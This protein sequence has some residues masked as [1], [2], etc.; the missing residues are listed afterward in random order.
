MDRRA[1]E[2]A[3][4]DGLVDGGEQ[5]FA[6]VANVAGV[7]SA[8]PGHHLR[9]SGQLGGAGVSAGDVDQAR[10]QA[11]GAGVHAR[12]DQGFHPLQSRRNDGGLG[13]SHHGPAHAALGDQ[14]ND[15]R[16][17]PLLADRGKIA[18]HVHRAT[19]AVAGDNRGHPLAQIVQVRPC[20]RVQDRPIGMR[21]QVDEP[22]SDHQVGGIDLSKPGPGLEFADGD[23]AVALDGHVGPEAGRAGAV[24]HQA[25]SK[26]VAPGRV[27]RFL[28]ITS[29]QRRQP[30]TGAGR[31]DQT[32]R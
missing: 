16:A 24:D 17:G 12:F 31:Q 28:T 18:R 5:P 21:M 14:M 6:L 2:S 29:T 9:Q 7:E 26:D 4:L 23:N 32:N 19:A 22:R 27:L 10:R 30:E 8:M 11:P 1:G 13:R 20:S 15:V 25:A 3:D